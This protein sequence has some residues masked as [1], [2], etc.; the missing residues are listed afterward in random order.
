MNAVVIGAGRIGC[1]LVGQLLRA[2]GYDVTFVTRS[3]EVVENFNRLGC[4]RLLLTSTSERREIL[5]T[6]IRAIQAERITAA[7]EAI[8]KADVIATAVCVQNLPY[9]ARL[10]AEGLSQ[11]QSPANIIA[12]ENME[13]AGGYLKQ[14]VACALPSH[15]SVEQHGFSGAVIGRMVTQ[16]LGDP[17]ANAPLTFVG[18]ALETFIV[19]STTM[20][21]P[22]PEIKGMKTVENYYPWVLRKLYTFSAG[23]AT[24]AYLGWLKGYHFIHTA[25]HD[26]EIRA[27]VLAAM[28]EGQRGLA[29]RF[30][31]EFAGDEQELE[32]IVARFENAAINDPITRVARD[33][34]RKLGAHERLVG[35]AKLAEEAGVFP[36]Q[37]AL[38]A[39]AALC[40]GNSAPPV[41]RRDVAKILNQICGL[42]AAHGFGRTVARS[43]AQLAPALSPG[44]LLL[45]LTQRTWNCA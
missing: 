26:Q 18:D 14:L 7:A 16:R 22:L 19:D 1:G 12:F 32:Q 8:S 29:A 17:A 43:W 38:A 5:V 9:A 41:Q 2:S 24:A 34:H 30:G 44:N 33:P 3:P 27:A 4:Y 13:D 37:L 39:A 6:G 28:A 40:F 23:H 45:S 42:D 20:R 31:Q 10:I 11:R 35:A 21:S 15:I 25:I 36:E